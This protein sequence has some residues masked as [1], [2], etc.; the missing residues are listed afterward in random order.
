MNSDELTTL[1][2]QGENQALEFKEAWVRPEQMAR[3]MVAFANSSGGTIVVGVNDLGGIVG[4]SSDASQEEWVMNIARNTVQPPLQVS[5]QTL[6]VQGVHLAVVQIPKGLDKPY[7]TGDKYYIRVGSTNRSPTQ[8]ELMRLYQLSGVF[9]YDAVAVSGTTANDLNQAAIDDYFSKYEIEFSKETPLERAAILRNA[10]LTTLDG[11][12]TVAGLLC[13]G[14]NPSRYLA[15]SGISFAHFAG[16]ELGDT[17]LDRQEINGTLA[18][19]I[20]TAVAIL[21]NRQPTPSTIEGALRI[22]NNLQPTDKALRELL[23]N[24]CVHRNYSIAG[25]KIRLFLFAD[26]LECHSPGR[27]PNTITLDKLRIGVSYA[28]NPVIVKFMDNLRYIDRLGRGF[29]LLYKEAKRLGHE[30]Q[31]DEVGDVL[32]VVLKL[33]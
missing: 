2:S 29:P 16:T 19:Q 13:F 22:E 31:V 8:A 28:S 11:E 7:Q 24:A 3:E 4:V 6:I 20:D 15:Q 17:L 18:Y 5:Y 30:L 32:R 25:S 33:G 9:H 14:I 12:C 1:I 21:K 23:V 27:L 26:R 10:D